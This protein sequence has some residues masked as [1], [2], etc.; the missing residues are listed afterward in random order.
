MARYTPPSP[1][2]WALCTLFF[3]YSFIVN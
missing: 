2:Q 1:A 3:I